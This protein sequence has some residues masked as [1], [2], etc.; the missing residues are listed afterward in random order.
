MCRVNMWHVQKEYHIT[1]QALEQRLGISSFETYL[2]RRRLRWLGHVGQE[3]T[4]GRSTLEDLR[5]AEEAGM[6]FSEAAVEEV[7]A[8]VDELESLSTAQLREKSAKS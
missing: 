5:L 1:A 2:V 6:V 8:G 4:Y 7:E 3:M